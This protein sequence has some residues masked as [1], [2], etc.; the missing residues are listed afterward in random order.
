M[1]VAFYT[2]PAFFEPAVHLIRELSRLVE[3]HVL[4]E[5]TPWTW[6]V[7]GFD[8]ARLD[9][10]AGVVPADR[11]LA[12]HLPL[13]TR[14]SLAHAADIQLVVHRQRRSLNPATW[15]IAQRALGFLRRLQ[16][17]ILHLDDADESL[18]LAL[19]GPWRLTTPLVL[20]VHDAEP[21]A[22]EADWH[23]RLARFLLFRRASRFVLYNKA[24]QVTF[25]R[26]YRIPDWLTRTVSLG[27][28]ELHEPVGADGGQDSG[29]IVLF[30]GRISLY[31]GLDVLYQAAPLVA[32]R[33][34][35]VRFVV[36]GRPVPRYRI[37]PP[38]P[39]PGGATID[40]QFEYIHNERMRTLFHSARV[41]AC[42]YLEATQSGVVLTSYGF[43]KPV[44]ASRTGGLPE[45][46]RDGETGLLVRPGDAQELADALVRVL[47]DSGLRHRFQQGIGE[48]M[49]GPLAWSNTA[50]SLV[51]VYAELARPR[52]TT[53]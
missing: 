41:V 5:V 25:A 27:A 45:Y 40:V 7:A 24:S 43:G 51:D 29:P 52:P 42:P 47:Q 15:I 33:V 18:R 37:P 35:G 26:R 23:T 8:I 10:P 14:E 28:Y 12:D 48:L 50:S 4:L 36:A 46:V 2:H 30:F 21:H 34:P 1:R 16:P 19:G 32:Q 20:S 11:V 6:Q 49:R 44:I 13:R 31:K 9:L 39:L 22:G 53:G 17:D 3:L 38:P